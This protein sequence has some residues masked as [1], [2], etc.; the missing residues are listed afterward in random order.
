MCSHPVISRRG[1][2]PEEGAVRRHRGAAEGV[3][4]PPRRAPQ[5]QMSD[6]DQS[7]GEGPEAPRTAQG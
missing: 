7:R 4:L 1:G 5:P 3:E 6:T 2:E